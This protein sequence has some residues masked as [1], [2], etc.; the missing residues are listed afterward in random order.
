VGGGGSGSGAF[1]SA[2]D[3]RPAQGRGAYEEEG[4]ALVEE[5]SEGPAAGGGAAEVECDI[6]PP[7]GWPADLPPP[8]ELGSAS[9]KDAEPLTEL[10]GGWAVMRGRLPPLGV[11][12]GAVMH[13]SAPPAA[14]SPS[15]WL[16]LFLPAALDCAEHQP[17]PSMPS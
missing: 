3:D 1:G 16:G 17:A 13:P 7:A 5:A 4:G 14:K 10:A 2:Y 11:G 6:P 15:R 8:E 9:S 12:T